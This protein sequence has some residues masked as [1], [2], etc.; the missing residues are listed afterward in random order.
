M[1]KRDLFLVMGGKL[2]YSKKVIATVGSSLIAY[3]PMWEAAGTTLTDISGNA[4]N[5]TYSATHW[6]YGVAGIGDGKTGTSVDGSAFANI[7]SAGLAAAFVGAEGSASLWATFP[8]T[9]G[10][11]TAIQLRADA[12]NRVS[13]AKSSGNITCAYVAGGTSKNVTFANA[14]TTWIHLGITWS[15]SGDAVK[16]YLNGQQTGSTQ[17][18]LSDWAGALNQDTC[19][20]ASTYGIAAIGAMV[21]SLCHVVISSRALTPAEMLKLG[22]V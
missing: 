10:T 4:R 15:K 17:T 9:T 13:I 6:T 1:R 12:N 16:A 5:G 2:A 19:S 11:G 18:T 21:G 22:T 14:A 7:Y 8:E 3:Y 20:L